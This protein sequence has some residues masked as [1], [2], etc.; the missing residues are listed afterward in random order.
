MKCKQRGFSLV[1]AIFL[2]VVLAGLGA[3]MVSFSTTQ[4]QGLAMD[5]MGS[6]AY[7]AASAGIEWAAYNVQ[8][9][10]GMS[11]P[12][13]TVVFAPS[14]PTALA[15]NLSDFAVTVSIAAASAVDD[16]DWPPDGSTVGD[17]VW[18]YDITAS[19]VWGTAGTE[20]RVERVLNAKMRE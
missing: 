12:V 9:N 7:Q 14:T 19:A 13:P 18:S 5:A 20:N 10:V 2:L 4:N 16:T 11:A 6:R 17:V 8:T 3:A 1:S 15:G